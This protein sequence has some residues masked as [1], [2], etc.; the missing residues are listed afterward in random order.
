M[1]IMRVRF[2]IQ[3]TSGLPG[4]HTTYWKG[5]SSSP[6]AADALD[7]VAR[8]R[9]FWNAVI[10]L[11]P[12]GLTVAC[13]QPVDILDET[14]GILV[15]QLPAGSPAT[16]TGTG[17]AQLPRASMMLLRYQTATIISGRRLQGRSFIGPCA[18]TTNT[19]GTVTPAS[20]TT[21]ITAS[22]Q[23]N[24]GATSSILQVWHRPT[25]AAPTSGAVAGVTSYATNTEFAVL[26]SR[27]D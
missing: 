19:G 2:N 14:T 9:A 21:L 13:N 20:Q 16:V 24:T 27:R 12:T 4:L 11:L 18:N 6:V 7:V 10:T 3:G 17:G 8:V 26:R 15:G 5:A 1:A 25:A 23:L 22:A